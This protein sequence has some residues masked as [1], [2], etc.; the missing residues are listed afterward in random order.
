MVP[1]ASIAGVFV[2]VMALAVP[3][4]QFLVDLGFRLFG[5]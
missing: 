1:T 3:L 4:V 2:G 5:I